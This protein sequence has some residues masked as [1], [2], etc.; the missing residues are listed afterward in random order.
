MY[1]ISLYGV[2]HSDVKKVGMV[3]TQNEFIS[4]TVSY[5]TL[6]TILKD[7]YVANINL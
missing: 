4:I 2:A 7:Y 5:H 1:L 6:N 3:M